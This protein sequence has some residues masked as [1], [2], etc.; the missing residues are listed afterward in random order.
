[1]TAGP[2]PVRAG[3][4]ALAALLLAAATAAAEPIAVPSQ[5]GWA[6]AKQR[7]A[8]GTGV[9][10][11]YVRMG[12]EAGRPI[13][14]IH[15]YSDNSRSW[16]LLAPH[17]A[18]RPLYAVDLRGHGA[19]DAP[20]CCYGPEVLAADVAGWMEMQGI[21]EADIV[22]HSLGAIVGAVLAATEPG[23]VSNLVLVSGATTVQAGPGSWLW[24][25]VRALDPPI[26]PAGKFM[27]D[28]YWNPNPV[29][30]DFLQREMAE[31]AA[32]PAQVWQ[33]VLE[34]LAITDWTQIAPAIEAPVLIL[35]GDQDALFDAASQERLRA[36]LPEAR[37]E[38]F[39]GLGHNL[40]W[41][42]P[43]KAASVIAAFLSE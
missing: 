16:S 42:D 26:D 37:F 21:A 8:T 24:D 31:S 34:G 36:A 33:G 2:S 6:G 29:D 25:N 41:E 17:L 22:G 30:A 39:A 28:W 14:L 4:A 11:A 40:A 15:G 9:E 19:S 18:D 12:A 13:V 32:M 5:E 1:V 35:W 38:T 7:A 20:A 23:K 3:G 27:T 43:E 10:L